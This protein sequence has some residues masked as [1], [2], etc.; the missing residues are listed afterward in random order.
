M[1]HSQIGLRITGTALICGGLLVFQILST[2]LLGMVLDGSVIIIAISIAMLGMG[3]ATSLMSLGARRQTRDS[4]SRLSWIGMLIGLSYIFSLILTA[5]MN[6]QFNTTLEK[7][8]EEG[9]IKL[10]IAFYLETLFLKMAVV[11]V[12]FFVP[13][14]FFGLFIAELF[15]AARTEDYHKLYAADLIGAAAGCVLSII[16]LD[17]FGYPGTVALILLSTFAGASAFGI[18]NNRATVAVSALAALLV[19]A[20][21][22]S[23]KIYEQLE[24]NPHIDAL[25]R[26]FD[27][28]NNVETGWHIWNAHSR[29]GLLTLTG[30]RTGSSWQVYAHENGDGWANV[31]SFDRSNLTSISPLAPLA[32]M[33]SPRRVLVLFAGVGADM[34]AIDA[35]CG[36]A[37]DITGVEIN[38]HMVEHALSTG[39]KRLAEF[40]AKDNIHLV[41]AEAREFLE[42]DKTKYDAILLSWWGAGVSHY[43]GSAGRLAQYLYT[44]EAFAA[45]MD[46]LTPEG[47]IV[48]YNGSKA[49]TLATLRE[50]FSERK[51]GPVDG[52]VVISRAKSA[53]LG[54]TGVLDVL[55]NMRLILKPSGFD[56]DDMSVVGATSAALGNE[57]IL[58]PEG[59]A[60]GY[61]LYRELAT[62][63]SL[64][65]I[66]DELRRTHDA[67]LSVTTDD[68]PFMDQVLPKSRYLDVSSWFSSGSANLEWRY[69]RGFIQFTMF[70]SVIS[71][72]L[73]LGPLL[74]RGGPQRTRENVVSLVYFAAL[75]AGFMAVEIG[76]V[77]KLGLIL[78][79]PAY[80]ISIVLAAL[81]MSTGF[82]SLKSRRVAALG[83]LGEKSTAALIALYVA[84]FTAAYPFFVS[85][86]IVLPTFYKACLTVALLF[87]LGFLMGQMFP[88]GLER[89]GSAD[90]QTV[91]WAWAVNSTL[92]TIG[93][94]VALLLSFPLG[95][96]MILYIGAMIYCVI[97]ILPLRQ[98]VTE[99]DAVPAPAGDHP[100]LP[101]AL[102]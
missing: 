89:A 101:T 67:E 4:W 88:W 83:T 99:Y 21:L 61:D 81:I 70:L 63:V 95:F 35:A 74:L 53:P 76:M 30:K 71:L 68:R 59:S 54:V 39:D 52:R 37:C 40:H 77:R 97:L 85:A 10:Y 80:A 82:G 64:D 38:R 47:I 78:G 25:A 92:S 23:P 28:A 73:I 72:V 16:A 22:A 1:S 90:P 41:V 86:I 15:G 58:Y 96:D 6:D 94:A 34:I 31:P 56:V 46:H 2:R 11:G 69:I 84:A 50:L 36:G 8:V 29:V 3:V 98:R 93:S 49:Q 13:Y 55:E 42:R 14:F 102:P 19:L 87:P 26:N 12:I 45:L 33:F 18:G 60:P 43:V 66:N 75:G 5:Q 27:R 32:T 100:N 57:L 7:A 79:H 9:G 20:A 65:T 44:K 48:S 51:L 91:P 62:G 24:P 17:W